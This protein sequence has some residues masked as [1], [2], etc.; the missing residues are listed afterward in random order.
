MARAAYSEDRVDEIQRRILA[1]AF[2]VI[3]SEGSSGLSLRRIAQELGW[4]AAALYRYF[5][6]KDELLNAIRA[7]G[8]VRMGRALETAIGNAASPCDAA[9]GGMRAYLAFARDQPELFR[10]MY[11]L[12]QAE[13]ETGPEVRLQRERAF[14]VAERIASQDP[15][16]RNPKLAA[17]LLWVS[18]HGLAAL[19]MAEQLDLG[20]DYEDLIEPLMEQATRPT[21]AGSTK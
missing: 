1:G 5:A 7:E 17:H 11:E 20:C 3:R 12:H 4:S 8:F 14:A 19:Q 21:Q 10:L 15:G 9:R 16:V 18:A 6:N 2:E 13:V